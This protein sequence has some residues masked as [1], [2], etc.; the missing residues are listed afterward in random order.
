MDAD[1]WNHSP[2]THEPIEGPDEDPGPWENRSLLAELARV[3]PALEP[4]APGMWI[5]HKP[6]FCREI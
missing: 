6:P 4:A 1:M 3:D 2:A 5:V